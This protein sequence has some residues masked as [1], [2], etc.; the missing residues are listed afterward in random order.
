MVKKSL[1]LT[2][3]LVMNL[4]VKQ[5]NIIMRH[6]IFALRYNWK[7]RLSGL[8]TTRQ[9]L[10]IREL[11]L[12]EPPPSPIDI[13]TVWRIFYLAATYRRHPLLFHLR[14]MRVVV[15]LE[16]SPTDLI[17]IPLPFFPLQTQMSQI[18]ELLSASDRRWLTCLTPR[19]MFCGVFFHLVTIC[20]HVFTYLSFI[21]ISGRAQASRSL[22]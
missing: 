12:V 1:T 5:A 11:V 13:M 4:T 10:I 21:F 15:L 7:A 19:G 20:R 8:Q 3:V 14:A 2:W 22:E 18:N 16:S 9:S 6:V 17:G